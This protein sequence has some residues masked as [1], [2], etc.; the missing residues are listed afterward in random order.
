MEESGSV[1][2]DELIELRKDTF[3]KVGDPSHAI[4]LE[5]N[6]NRRNFHEFRQFQNFFCKRFLN[7][8]FLKV[9]SVTFS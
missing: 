3:F 6:F 5:I 4:F 8:N 7:S 9:D 1:G 2:L